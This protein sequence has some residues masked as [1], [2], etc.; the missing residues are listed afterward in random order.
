M[1]LVDHVL[2]DVLDYV[3]DYKIIGLVT[4]ALQSDLFQ[5]NFLKSYVLLFLSYKLSHN[6]IFYHLLIW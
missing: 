1:M 6:V 2:D 3:L 5:C 4:R